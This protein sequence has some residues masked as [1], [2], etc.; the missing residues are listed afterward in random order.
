MME[1]VNTMAKAGARRQNKSLPEAELCSS[2]GLNRTYG[3][4]E[5][6]LPVVPLVLLRLQL[7]SRAPPA[8]AGLCQLRVAQA[9]GSQYPVLVPR[10]FCRWTSPPQ[11]V[12]WPVNV[13]DLL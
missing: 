1:T 8:P 4:V 6:L 3:E 9:A 13:M 10:A 12:W 7:E 5:Q 11:S 2:R